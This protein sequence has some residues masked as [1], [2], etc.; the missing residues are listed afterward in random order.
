MMPGVSFGDW[1]APG[2]LCLISGMAGSQQGW[3]EAPYCPCPAGFDDVAACLTWIV[4]GRIAIV[5]PTM[6]VSTT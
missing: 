6:A 4:P 5:P 3:L 2:T 1:M